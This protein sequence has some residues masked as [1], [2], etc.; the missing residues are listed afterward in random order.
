MKRLLLPLLAGMLV[1][2]GPP[3]RAQDLPPYVGVWDCSV[4]IFTFTRESYNNGSDIMPFSDIEQDGDN[5]I[6]SFAD[7]YQIGVS[8][9]GDEA[10]QWLSMASG[11][12]FECRRLYY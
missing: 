7:G 2:G 5:F 6:I 1:A 4:G 11:D 10:M 12:S 8:M 9:N 3:A